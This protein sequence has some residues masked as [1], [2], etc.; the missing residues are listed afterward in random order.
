MLT[1]VIDEEDDRH[2]LRSGRR[3][4]SPSLAPSTAP[5]RLQSRVIAVEF[6]QANFSCNIPR[7]T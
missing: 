4:G 3:S 1:I 2:A 7:K 6:E 5:W